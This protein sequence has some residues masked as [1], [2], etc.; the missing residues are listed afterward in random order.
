MFLESSTCKVGGV[1]VKNAAFDLDSHGNVMIPSNRVDADARRDDRI[2]QF[3][4]LKEMGG[5][6]G[7]ATWSLKYKQ[8]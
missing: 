4:N 6:G 7:R 5:G 3:I 2:L 8:G 1:G